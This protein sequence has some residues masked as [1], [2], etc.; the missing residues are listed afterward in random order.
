MSFHCRKSSRQTSHLQVEGVAA[1]DVTAGLLR[2]CYKF[3]QGRMARYPGLLFIFILI[4][5]KLYCTLSKQVH[6]KVLGSSGVMIQEP[7]Q[8]LDCSK[9]SST[10]YPK[11]GKQWLGMVWQL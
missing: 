4:C 9:L 3:K 6:G 2:L 10:S 1:S 7:I 5:N 8:R 11:I